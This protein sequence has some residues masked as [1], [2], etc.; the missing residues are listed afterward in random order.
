M[1]K[2]EKEL[3]EYLEVTKREDVNAIEAWFNALSPD[4]KRE[5]ALWL[6]APS[7]KGH[8]HIW[9]RGIKESSDTE[10]EEEGGGRAKAE[11]SLNKGSSK[12]SSKEA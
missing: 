5:F 7:G 12:G 2:I 1:I 6:N 9:A 10:E 3:R 11:Q 4:K 8:Q